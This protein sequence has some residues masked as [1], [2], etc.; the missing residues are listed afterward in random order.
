MLKRLPGSEKL[1]IK[2]RFE[3]RYRQLLGKEY[4][5]FIE[6]SLSYITKSIRAN[7]LKINQII[8]VL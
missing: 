6:H 5:S 7:T 1:E 3:K 8:S 4:E 2:E